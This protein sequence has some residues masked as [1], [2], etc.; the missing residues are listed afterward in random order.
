MEDKRI[1][2][3]VVIMAGGFGTRMRKISSSIPKPLIE[4]M[5]KPMIENVL[6]VFISQ[7]FNDFHIIL[8]YKSHIIKSYIEALELPINIKF[9]IEEDPLGTA[10]GLKLLKNNLQETFILCNCDNLGKFDYKML[11]D[12]H[13]NKG[14]LVTIPVI[15][16]NYIIP[17]GIITE[18]DGK[19]III[20]EN[21]VKKI[22]ISTGIHIINLRFIDYIEDNEKI[23][24]PKLL[25]RARKDE[26][27]GCIYV[28]ES[29]WTDM[30]IINN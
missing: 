17:Y 2:I 29:Q 20:N 24:M 10:G 15:E 28:D 26:K 14:Y 30:S 6:N 13:T 11:I 18:K 8:H 25:N 9:Y 23:D 3:S 21:P 12:E 5:G 16:K 4:Y 19:F 22:T 27:I 1:N 7:G